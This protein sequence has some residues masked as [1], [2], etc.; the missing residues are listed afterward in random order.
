MARPGCALDRS[1]DPGTTRRD[2]PKSRNLNWDL[3]LILPLLRREAEAQIKEG[4]PL[5]L[6][7][8][9]FQEDPRPVQNAYLR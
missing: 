6:P 1:G 3:R 5:Y 4:R 2:R 8:N 7:A 9:V